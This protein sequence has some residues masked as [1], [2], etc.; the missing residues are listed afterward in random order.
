MAHEAE[1]SP[2]AAASLLLQCIVIPALVVCLWA[3]VVSALSYVASSAR[4]G[5]AGSNRRFEIQGGKGTHTGA[6]ET[7]PCVRRRSAGTRD[8]WLGGASLKGHTR[9]GEISLSQAAIHNLGLSSRALYLLYSAQEHFS[10]RDGS[11]LTEGVVLEMAL[12]Q[13]NHMLQ[14]EKQG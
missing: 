11:Q 12:E 8:Q 3:G 2:T 10:Q 13:L 7:E 9:C 6:T 4:L 1:M 14:G 5:Q